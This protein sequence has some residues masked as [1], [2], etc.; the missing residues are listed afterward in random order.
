MNYLVKKIDGHKISLIMAIVMGLVSL[1]FYPFI[2]I[3][4]LISK[5]DTSFFP[6]TST[7][8]IFLIMP[9]LYFG[10]TYVFTR[11]FCGLFNIIMKKLK[12]FKIE[13]EEISNTPI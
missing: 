11:L 1:I 5:G 8:I 2:L 9:L 4:F 12:G 6:Y 10:M 13:I 3:S 7:S